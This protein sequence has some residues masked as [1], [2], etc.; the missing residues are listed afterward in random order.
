MP[1]GV[2]FSGFSFKDMTEAPSFVDGFAWDIYQGSGS[3]HIWTLFNGKMSQFPQFFSVFTRTK[4]PLS[5][6][7]AWEGTKKLESH[8]HCV[9][10]GIYA[11]A[12]HE[13]AREG[14]GP[15]FFLSN[16]SKHW[17]TFRQLFDTLHVRWLSRILNSTACNYQ[18]TN[19][20]E[21]STWKITIWL[22]DDDE[23]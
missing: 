6:F 16:T 1:A 12:I 7:F 13:K 15:S 2:F 10:L 5:Y 19:R 17:Q 4:S 22:L 3:I 14:R 18:T 11:L 23:G 9:R 21:L 8:A 20:G